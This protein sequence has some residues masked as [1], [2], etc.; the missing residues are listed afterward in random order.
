MLSRLWVA[1]PKTL[2][3]LGFEGQICNI[4]LQGVKKYKLI[5][6]RLIWTN[7]FFQKEYY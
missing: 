7:F 5:A 3:G 4:Q 6:E 1:H 2:L